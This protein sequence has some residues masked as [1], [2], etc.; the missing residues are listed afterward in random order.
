[1]RI[2]HLLDAPEAV[3]T[4]VRWFVAE[5]EPWYGPAGD[6]DAESD[7]AACR[8]RGALPICLVALNEASAALGTAAL[9]DES[10]GS[11]LGVGPWL[12]GVLVSKENRGAGVGKALIAAIED[13]ARRLGFGAIYTSADADAATMRRQ[14]WHEHGA[15]QSLRGRVTVYRRQLGDGD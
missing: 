15:A 7:F 10:V 2:V 6:G 4:L 8:D 9:R 5:W 3:P 13:E 12:A 14:G 11:E 1:M